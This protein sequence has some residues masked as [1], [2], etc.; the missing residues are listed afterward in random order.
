MRLRQKMFIP[1]SLLILL[2]CGSGSMGIVWLLSNLKQDII[3]RYAMNTMAHLNQSIDVTAGQAL[4]KAALFSR[5]PE[6]IKAFEMAHQGD[7]EDEADAMSQSARVMIRNEMKPFMQ[8]FAEATQNQRFKLHFHLPGGRSLVR[9]WRDQQ[10]QRDGK[11]MDLTDDISAFRNT[12]LD[13]NRL[14]K[15]IKGIELGRGGFVIRGVAPVKNPDGKILGSVEVLSDF[16]PLLE[17]MFP[18]KNRHFLL[19]MNQSFLDITHRLQDSEK[20]P[21]VAEKYIQVMGK[22]SD[23]IKNLLDP[24]LIQQGQ[25]NLSMFFG[26]TLALAAFPVNDYKLEQIGV[27][28]LGM[29]VSKEHQ[30]IRKIIWMQVG[31]LITILVVITFIGSLMMNRFVLSPIAL[32]IRFM[33]RI[34]KGDLATSL[35]LET[36]DEVGQLA[37]SMDETVHSFGTM[38]KKIA[39]AAFSLTK[40]ARDIS[41]NLDNQASAASEQSASVSEITATMTEFS[42]TSQQIAENADV[43]L[44]IAEN[45]L[46]FAN[47]GAQSVSAVTEKMEEIHQDNQKTAVGI[48]ELGHRTREITKIMEIINSIADQTKL[49]AF[50]A[51]IEASSAGEAGKRFGVVAVEIRRLADNVVESTKEIEGKI[52]EIQTAVNQM[53]INSEKSGKSVHEGMAFSSHT[54]EKLLSIVDESRSTRDAAKQ[55]SLST[56][57][58]KTAS[59]QVVT[60]LQEIDEGSRQTTQGAKQVSDTGK[61]LEKLAEQLETLVRNFQI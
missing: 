7:I 11:W 21:V 48:Q 29:D 44:E 1:V 42:A 33:E 12:V 19:L 32:I 2:L 10:I 54:T 17:N 14:G 55:I 50:N 35:K 47:D 51:A 26:Q 43:V 46:N 53:V 20:Y 27:M 8:G 28:V 40:H 57:Q 36:Q 6:M 16:Q 31:L 24:E 41:F 59:K 13:V 56:Q 3:T 9:L 25:Q 45:A 18:G 60:A 22:N 15:P 58:Q 52:H 30:R 5:M 38:V 61:E 23:P 39:E 4:E 37:R 34:S 49:I